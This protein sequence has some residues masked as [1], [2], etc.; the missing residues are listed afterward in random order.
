MR[1][2]HAV[3][4]SVGELDER[5]GAG[6]GEDV[7]YCVRCALAGIDVMLALDSYVLH[8]MGKSTWRGG[9]SDE[10]RR[11][12]DQKY[13]AAFAQ[14]WGQPLHDLLLDGRDDDIRNDNELATLF[15]GGQYGEVFRRL[16][17]R[18]V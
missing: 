14:K 18:R 1:V 16:M 17:Q 5:F 2:P 4:E 7:D 8:F 15:A 6:G 11:A 9:E 12:R 13:R 3:F 10:A